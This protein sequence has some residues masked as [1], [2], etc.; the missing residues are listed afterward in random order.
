MNTVHVPSE[1]FRCKWGAGLVNYECLDV[2]AVEAEA[3]KHPEAELHHLVS[4]GS[5]T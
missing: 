3:I 4:T 1:G 5:G 2:S